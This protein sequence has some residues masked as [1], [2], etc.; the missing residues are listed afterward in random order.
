MKT[1][2][3]IS[4]IVFF[5]QYVIL[6]ISAKSSCNISLLNYSI[7]DGL[8]NNKINALFQDSEGYLWIGTK[9][10]L[11]RYNG[12]EF[13]IFKNHYGDTNTISDN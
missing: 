11:N 12:Y 9:D 3:F 5:L 1:L 13:D 7:E 6:D 8:S 10:G 2:S 4:I